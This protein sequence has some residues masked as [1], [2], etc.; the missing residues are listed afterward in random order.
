MSSFQGV[1]NREVFQC[2]LV[3]YY[4]S[5][6]DEWIS[7]VCYLLPGVSHSLQVFI[8]FSS[9]G[10]GGYVYKIS[11]IP[12]VMHDTTHTRQSF[13][14]EKLAAMGGEFEHT[15]LCSTN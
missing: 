5:I 2:T 11:E 14:K 3:W 15:T 12:K 6:S 10:R 7:N 9:A 1:L 8:S 4:R 13:L